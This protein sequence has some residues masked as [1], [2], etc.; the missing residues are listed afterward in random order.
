MLWYY[1]LLRYQSYLHLPILCS[2]R[3][4]LLLQ[5]NLLQQDHSFLSFLLH[6]FYQVI[7]FQQLQLHLLQELLFLSRIHILRVLR[8][9]FQHR[10]Y[11][12]LYYRLLPPGSYLNLPILCNSRVLLLL[13]YNLRL[14]DHSFLS[15]R[16][17]PS[18]QVIRYLHLRLHLLQV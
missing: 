16:L 6:Q 3:E 18:F 1:R 10:R 5:Y 13:Q 11:M 15:F 14:Q 2:F 9:F 4:L 8:V 17:H 7:H 12:L